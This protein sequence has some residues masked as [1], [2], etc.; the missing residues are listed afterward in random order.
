MNRKNDSL[1]GP[2]D[3]TMAVAFLP[4]SSILAHNAYSAFA[5]VLLAST[6]LPSTGLSALVLRN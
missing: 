3:S 2:L 5:R 4:F 1:R 6:Q